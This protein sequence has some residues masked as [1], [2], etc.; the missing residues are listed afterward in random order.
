MK[1][2]LRINRFPHAAVSVSRVRITN[3]RFVYVICTPRAQPYPRGKSRIVYIGT[4]KQGV[5]RV[6]ASLARVADEFLVRWGVRRLDAY[7]VSCRPRQRIATWKLLERDMLIVFKD[8]FRQVPMHNVVG[9]NYS[10][11]KLSR[12]FTLRGLT[13]I[14]R[15]FD[16]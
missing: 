9:K 13:S 5:H 6:S 12:Q 15:S 10:P 7:V 2:R 3:R 8:Q 1:R 11:E 4:T 16:S 14:V